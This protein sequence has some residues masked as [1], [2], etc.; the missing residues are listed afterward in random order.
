MI[1]AQTT[2][3]RKR[4]ATIFFFLI[5]FL[6]A[7]DIIHYLVDIEQKALDHNVSH[8]LP[9]PPSFIMFRSY[10]NSTVE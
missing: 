1:I 6:G 2:K 10:S 5:F 7:I 9:H 3:N 4:N 8:L